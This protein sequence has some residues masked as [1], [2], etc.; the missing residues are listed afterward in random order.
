MSRGNG[1]MTTGR[2]NLA[3]AAA[4][5]AVAATA[6]ALRPAVARTRRSFETSSSPGARA[7]DLLAGAALGGYYDDIAADCA[8][9]LDAAG[10]QS[11]SIL[12]IG[13]GPGHLAERLLD[14]LPGARWTGIDSDP[15]MLAAAD[16]K[17]RRRGLMERA[18]LVEAD[19]AALPFEDTGFDLVV[20]SFSAHHWPDPRAGFAE[21]R[22]VLRPCGSA[23]VF[24]FP[25]AWGR[26]ETGSPGTD[27]ADAVFEAPETSTFRGIGP[28]A[29]VR[30]VELMKPG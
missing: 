25:V 4:V 12:E 13:P 3:L 17:L 28:W 11:P 23:L 27:G 19:V 22:R 24:D 1:K 15:A 18:T 16:A 2:Q 21:I 8:T 9:T 14:L 10:V 29:V 20:T 30:R 7:Y 26:F 6:I 5:I